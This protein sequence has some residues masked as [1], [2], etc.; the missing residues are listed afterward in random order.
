MKKHKTAVV[1][2]PWDGAKAIMEARSPEALSH[3]HAFFQEGADPAKRE[4]YMF[5]HHEAGTDTPANLAAVNLALAR[6][7]ESKIPEGKK[8]AIAAHL[9]AHRVDAGLPEAMSKEEIAEAVKHIKKADDLHVYEADIMAEH[10]R[11]QERQNLAEWLESRLHLHLTI[12]AD[13][14][15]GDGRV[16]RDERKV[17]SGAIGVALDNYHQFLVDNAPQLF[18]RSSW[19]DAPDPAQQPVTAAMA[20]AVD[21]REAGDGMY[22]PLMEKAVRRDGTIPIKIIQPGWGSS[23]YYPAEVLE[24]DGPQIFQKGMHMYWNHPTLTEDAERPERDLKDLAA[25]LSSDARWDAKGPKGPGLYADAKVFDAYQSHVDSLAENIGVSIRAMGKA[26]QG[27]VDGRTGPIITELTAGRSVDFVT[28]PGAGGEILT[29]FE[30]AR[31][32][33]TG[34]N[35]DAGAVP[36]LAATDSVAITE[37]TSEVD[38]EMKDLQEAVTTLQTQNAGLTANN[39]RMAERL[40]M[41]DA[42]DLVQERLSGLQLPQATKTRLL[43]T[44][45]AQFV[46]K[47]G[48][49]DREA[50]GT[51]VKEAIKTEVQYLTDTLGLGNIKGLGESDNGEEE[52]EP[53]NV[54]EALTA[55]FA[56]MGLSESAAKH[57]AQGRN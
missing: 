40:A 12:I 57:A 17:L 54:E 31:T 30:A 23:G 19:A 44:L 15:F 25:V 55:S 46:L 49:L 8:L 20:E 24:R 21:L 38:M 32:V 36:A 29:L 26:Q 56:S 45:P 10:I 48:E 52:G 34:Q 2:T 14:M 37:S 6:L 43:Q 7:C 13:D 42:R 3:M 47:E 51:I 35:P 28:A 9:R 22:M 39:A 4:S 1:T 53:E 41:R 16:T 27:T 50:F 18:Q 33:R 11:L 5:A